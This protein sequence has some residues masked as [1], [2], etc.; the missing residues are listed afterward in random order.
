M[1]VNSIALGKRIQNFIKK[2]DSKEFYAKL[3]RNLP[4][5]ETFSAGLCYC[6]AIQLQ[7]NLPKERKPSLMWQA[8]LGCI[9][10]MSV[11]KA[12][13]GFINKHK[14]LLCKEL[15]KKNIPK[16]NNV[17]KGTRVFVPLVTSALV[18]RYA[19]PVILVPISSWLSKHFKKEKVV[20]LNKGVDN[21]KYLA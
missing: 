2:T 12:L 13:D 9:A 19:I 15:E 10:G 4:I 14:E 11:S 17:I 3:D 1:K 6:G 18:T 7:N 8:I 21:K 5:L 16:V 20:N